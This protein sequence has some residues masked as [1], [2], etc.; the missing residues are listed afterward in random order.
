MHVRNRTTAVRRIV[1]SP[2]PELPMQ[3]PLEQYKTNGV[4]VSCHP[5]FFPRAGPSSRG[6]GGSHDASPPLC[7]GA[8]LLCPSC[9][10]VF[11][12]LTACAH[13]VQA[14]HVSPRGSTV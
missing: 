14:R 13:G 1:P 7:T 5:T 4:L 3:G 9:G 6:P 12:F 11:V 2:P 10:L 8:S